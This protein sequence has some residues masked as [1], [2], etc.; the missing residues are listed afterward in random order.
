MTF[1]YLAF[2]FTFAFIVFLV[3]LCT[4]WKESNVV[5]QL[6]SV[7]RCHFSSPT[8]AFSIPDYYWGSSN[9]ISC[10]LSLGFL[11]LLRPLQAPEPFY[12]RPSEV[13]IPHLQ[14]SA[15]SSILWGW[16]GCL[17][18]Q[19]RC[20]LFICSSH[21]LMG[22]SA[23]IKGCCRWVCLL[24]VL[25]CK[26][27]IFHYR[28]HCGSDLQRK[29]YAEFWNVAIKAGNLV[30]LPVNSVATSYIKAVLILHMVWFRDSIKR[31]H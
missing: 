19:T 13:I 24:E 26:Y 9:I 4:Y 22:Q 14:G 5:S 3:S 20:L 1:F 28:V 12:P 27:W 18:W 10:A 21:G 15:F 29:A 11:F 31:K 7:P 6:S 25:V 17:C 8:V 30:S 16:E 2:Q 23:F